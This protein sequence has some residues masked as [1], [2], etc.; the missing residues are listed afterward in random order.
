MA[1]KQTAQGE[2]DFMTVAQFLEKHGFVTQFD[3]EKICGV[4]FSEMKEGLCG[5]ESSLA[6]L[7]AFL[8]PVCGNKN[9]RKCVV[10]D[11][12]GTNLRAGI[13]SFGENGVVIDNFKETRL[14]GSNGEISADEL[15]VTLARDGYPDALF[16]NIRE[17]GG[18]VVQRFPGVY[19]IEGLFHTP[20]QFLVTGE[21][22]PELHA[23]LRILTKRAKEQDVENFLR[24]AREFTEPGDRHNADAILQLS[25]SANREV[26]EEIKRRDPV[27]CEALRDLMKDEIQ[28]ERQDAADIVLIAAIKNAMKT[29]GV[30]ASKAMEGL[31]ISPSD[32]IRYAS[33]L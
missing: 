9:G 7:P 30:D 6:M 8:S 31:G 29:F 19:Y 15:T 23:S 17:S 3:M 14:P 25:V 22:D 16:K 1:A 32:Q 11:A 33:R 13:A 2:P 28:E 12:G 24:M 4:Y 21:L 20:S 18:T 10:I 5:R 26:Y 27:M